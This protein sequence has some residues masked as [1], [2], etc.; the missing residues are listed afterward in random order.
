MHKATLLA[1]IDKATLLAFI[2]KATLL[3][4]IDKARRCLYNI[5]YPA[6]G[7]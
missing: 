1:F 4:F 3:A 6:I 5:L 7:L 2:D